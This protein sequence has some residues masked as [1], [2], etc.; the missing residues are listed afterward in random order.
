MDAILYGHN[1]QSQIHNGQWG[2]K[3]C[4]DAGTATIKSRSEWIEWLPWFKVKAAL[5]MIHLDQD[6]AQSDYILELL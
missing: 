3:R 1:H 4:Y 5:A 2:I 6:N